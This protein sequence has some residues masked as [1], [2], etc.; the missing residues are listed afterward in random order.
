MNRSTVI[1]CVNGMWQPGMA[2]IYKAPA[3]FTVHQ[4]QVSLVESC[5]RHFLHFYI[6]SHCCS[7]YMLLLLSCLSCQST[8]VAAFRR[9]AISLSLTLTHT[10]TLSLSHTH[11]HTHTLGHIL[12]LFAEILTL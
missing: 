1:T 11:S 9:L 6:S 5:R 10:H 2:M 8:K 4:S 3:F 12:S 7:T